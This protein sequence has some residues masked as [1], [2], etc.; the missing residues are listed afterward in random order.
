MQCY[1]YMCDVHVCTHTHTYLYVVH[2]PTYMYIY[3]Y[4]I[5]MCIDQGYTEEPYPDRGV[6][7]GQG[8][9]TSVAAQE[10]AG[11]VRHR[12]GGGEQQ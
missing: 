6:D 9:Q 1:A 8:N 3:L 12:G 5:Y 2:T 11:E 7:R 4:L 10:A